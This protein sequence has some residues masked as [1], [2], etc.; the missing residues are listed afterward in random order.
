ADDD[1]LVLQGGIVALL[2]TGVE[3]VAVDMGDGEV[4]ELAMGDD[5]RRA[6]GRAAGRLAAD[7]QAVAAQRLH[8]ASSGRQSQAAPRTP[9]ASPWRGGRIRAATRSEKTWR[10]I[11]S[12]R[13]RERGGGVSLPPPPPPRAGGGGVRPSARPPA[14]AAPE[15]S[16]ATH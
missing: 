13:R 14:P 4:L 8:T 7:L 3:S 2:D 16:G 6:A 10:R 1:R 11:S 15:R 5:A 12:G 9:L